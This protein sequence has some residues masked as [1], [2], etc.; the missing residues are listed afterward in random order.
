VRFVLEPNSLELPSRDLPAKH[1]ILREVAA[2]LDVPVVDLPA[3]IGRAEREDAGFLWW[4]PVHPT[5]FGQA[6]AAEAIAGGVL[7]PTDWAREFRPPADRRGP[8]GP[9]GPATRPMFRRARAVE[10]A[11]RNHPNWRAA[12]TFLRTLSILTITGLLVAAGAQAAIGDLAGV[13]CGLEAG[14]E[15]CAVEIAPGTVLEGPVDAFAEHADANGF[16]FDDGAQRLSVRFCDPYT[17]VPENALTELCF[18]SIRG[19]KYAEIAQIGFLGALVTREPPLTTVG[20]DTGANLVADL[21]LAP[22]LVAMLDDEDKY[23]VYL[24]DTAGFSAEIPGLDFIRLSSGGDRTAYVLGMDELF[25]YYEGELP[26]LP[27]KKK[28]D[29]DAGSDGTSDSG[30]SDSTGS[31]DSTPSDTT[32]DS[33]PDS[34]TETSSESDTGS[35]DAEESTEETE[36]EEGENPSGAVAIKFDGGIPWA[37]LRNRG[38]EADL[39]PFDGHIYVKGPIPVATGFEIDGT[40]VFDVDPDDDGD[41]PFE[42]PFYESVDLT[43]G[44]NGVL[45]M[46]LPMIE[47]P[48]LSLEFGEASV[49]GALS[50][51]RDAFVFSGR[52]SPDDFLAGL[53]IPLGA[54]GNVEGWGR[55]VAD[56]V[57]G[58]YAHLEGAMGV[59]G[60]ALGALLG[61]ELGTLQS[62]DAVLDVNAAGITLQGSTTSALHPDL[63]PNGSIGMLVHV[64]PNPAGWVME[65]RG[66]LTVAGQGLRDAFVRVDAAGVTVQGVLR[67]GQ[68]DF[69][70][71]GNLGPAGLVIT[72]QVA[73]APIAANGA[74]RALAAAAVSDLLA[75][76][77]AA[78]AS[79]DQAAAAV[80]S[81]QSALVDAQATLAS[82][83]SALSSAQ[84]SLSYYES[85]YSYHRS[86][87]NYWKK[88]SC[89]WYDAE[90]QA[91]RASKLAYYSGKMSYYAGKITLYKGIVASA[92]AA[93]AAAQ[94]T[95]DAA[96]AVLGAAAAELAALQ[97]DLASKQALLAEAEARLASLPVIDAEIEMTVTVHFENGVFDGWLEVSMG[98]FALGGGTLDFG[99][100]ATA[101]VTLPGSPAVC[102]TF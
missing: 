30:T 11:L 99:P 33:T 72:G 87:Y 81:A 59:D 29:D 97:A 32:S 17:E 2:A 28:K 80:A 35:S 68:T 57:L 83:Q 25:F 7:E 71:I 55:F 60:A 76:V 21:A 82:A 65:L 92:K 45:Q 48:G 58:T 61:L 96:Q 102:Q 64:G 86:K 94:A 89:K 43:V 90:C 37:P 42:L 75:Q 15:R 31:S 73:L 38:V 23:L 50:E 9:S 70:V 14:V 4:D 39:L 47:I 24:S 79:V 26:G 69:L 34:T 98:G 12:M 77:E 3:A 100:P 84:G 67:Q 93:V 66:D 6:L 74:E 22:D 20:L 5:S 85:K 56:D 63:A 10:T 27:P 8:S 36:E 13:D 78:Q 88:K 95:V 52:V 18:D 19:T 51:D 40:F 53:P 44:A 49:T 62:V 54:N 91:K 46:A 16:E 101:C 41:H 1:A